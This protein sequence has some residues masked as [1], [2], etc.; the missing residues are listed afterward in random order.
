MKIVR[1]LTLFSISV[2]AGPDSKQKRFG[3]PGKQREVLE[4][5]VLREALGY[6]IIMLLR[7]TQG[8]PRGINVKNLVRIISFHPSPLIDCM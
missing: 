7:I 1:W 5:P 3:V 6:D 4:S 8:L 2:I